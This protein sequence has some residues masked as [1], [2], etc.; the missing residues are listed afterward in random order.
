MGTGVTVVML[1]LLLLLLLVVVVVVVVVVG[2]VGVVF[3]P[4]SS[5]ILAISSTGPAIRLVPVSAIA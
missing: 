4:M 2:V 3:A 5:L 1:L